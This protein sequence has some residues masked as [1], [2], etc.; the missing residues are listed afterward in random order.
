M[1]NRLIIVISTNL[2]TGYKHTK[3]YNQ[4]K[5]IILNISF[6][7]FSSFSSEIM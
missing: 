1:N 7:R 4:I 3:L 6:D 5:N 2:A